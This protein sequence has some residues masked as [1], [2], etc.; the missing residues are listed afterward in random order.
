M[1]RFLF[2]THGD[3]SKAL[4]NTVSMIIG[5][6]P[7]VSYF[8]MTKLKS[9][10]TAKKELK[11]ILTDKEEND[12]FIVLTDM[13]GGSVCNICSELFME[14]KNFD[15]LTGVNLPMVLTMLLAGEEAS[16][17]DTISQGFEAAKNGI[18]HINEIIESQ[19]GSVQDDITS[20]N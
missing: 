16:I 5:D 4:I 20:E 10:A 18:I 3:L 9:S 15:L 1:K 14:L 17:A 7:N 13:F 19:K 11:E 6:M 12:H 2:A 8:Q